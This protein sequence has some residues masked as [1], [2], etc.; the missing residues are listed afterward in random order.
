VAFTSAPGVDA[1]LAAADRIGRRADLLAAM[2][3]GVL[4]I[5]VG[6]MT[7]APLRATGLDPAVPDRHRLGAMIRLICD[8]LV[9]DQAVR[10]RLGDNVRLELRGGLVLVDDRPVSLAPHALELLRLLV[11]N[12]RVVLRAELMGCLSDEPDDHALDVAMSR[13][14]QSLGV[15]GLINTVVRRGYRFAGTRQV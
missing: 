11:D 14:R 1:T 13:L 4:P 12:D 5:A 2:A 8:R 6:P 7:A 3:G 10:F 15:P 9:A